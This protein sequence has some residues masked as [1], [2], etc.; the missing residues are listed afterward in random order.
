MIRTRESASKLYVIKIFLSTQ[1]L[2]LRGCATTPDTAQHHSHWH[3]AELLTVQA[4]SMLSCYPLVPG[5]AQKMFCVMYGL[6]TVW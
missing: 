5:Q 3:F 6:G 1:Q 4:L 2:Q